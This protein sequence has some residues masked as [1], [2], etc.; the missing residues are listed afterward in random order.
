[1]MATNR[2]KERGATIDFDADDDTTA[3][4]HA[5]RAARAPRTGPGAIMQSLALGREV[6]EENADLKAKLAHFED[7]DVIEV[8]DP[9]EIGPSAFANRLEISFAT[10]EYEELK[11]EIDAAGGNIQPIKVRRLA[12]PRGVI[13]YEI[14]FGHRRHHACLELGLKI[15]VFVEEQ[16][17]DDEL[18]VQMERENRGRANLTPWEQGVFYAKLLD[19]KVFRSIRQLGERLGVD[20]ASASRA[21]QLASLPIEVVAAF[22][23]PL[24]LQLRWGAAIQDAINRDGQRVSAVA[25]E[26]TRMSPRPGAKEVFDRLLGTSDGA[27]KAEKVEIKVKGGRVGAIWTR[28]RSGAVALKI[29]AG[30]MS[31]A[32]ERRLLELVQKALE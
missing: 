4:Q 22:G 20:I 13:K 5:D 11:R 14:V 6:V 32:Q 25:A 16:M 18:A 12:K 24:E 3:S 19:K 17:A 27:V 15:R 7:V 31:A 21:V 1:M 2:L 29:R 30:T 8:L 26:L 23:S 10:P 9:A 28:D